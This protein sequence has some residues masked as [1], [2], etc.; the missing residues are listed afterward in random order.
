MKFLVRIS[1]PVIFFDGSQVCSS[2]ISIS[3]VHNSEM[4]K[5]R[6]QEKM[7]TLREGCVGG[8]SSASVHRIFVQFL[9]QMPLGL[10]CLAVAAVVDS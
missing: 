1:G 4:I 5:G 9:E 6:I 2:C 7:F 8:G 10:S 3:S